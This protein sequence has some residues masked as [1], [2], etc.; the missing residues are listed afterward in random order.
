M[1]NESEPPDEGAEGRSASAREQDAALAKRRSSF[2]AVNDLFRGRDVAAELLADVWVYA[3]HAAKPDEALADPLENASYAQAQDAHDRHKVLDQYKDQ[4]EQGAEIRAELENAYSAQSRKA[5]AAPSPETPGPI[6]AVL[7][8]WSSWN[9]A[10]LADLSQAAAAR[11]AALK[12]ALTP[13][14]ETTLRDLETGKGSTLATAKIFRS[15]PQLLDVFPDTPLVRKVR[16]LIQMLNAPQEWDGYLD[17]LWTLGQTLL[18]IVTGDPWVVDQGSNDSGRLRENWGQ[19]K[20]AI[21]I[22]TL[23]LPREHV[24][25]MADELRRRCL[26][27]RMTA[28]DG[29]SRRIPKIE[30]RHLKIVL[31]NGNNPFVQRI[32]QSTLEPATIV[33]A[34]DDVV[35]ERVEVLREFPPEER[36]ED[37]GVTAPPTE[38][39]VMLTPQ[40]GPSS[41]TQPEVETIDLPQG[42]LSNSIMPPRLEIV[43]C[44]PTT[45]SNSPGPSDVQAEWRSAAAPAAVKKA[46]DASTAALAPITLPMLEAAAEEPPG[47]EPMRERWLVY[48]EAVGTIQHRLNASVGRSQAIFVKA[49]TSNE[50]RCRVSPYLSSFD[51]GLKIDRIDGIVGG[52]LRGITTATHRNSLVPGGSVKSWAQIDPRDVEVDKSDLSDWLNQQAPIASPA[53]QAPIPEPDDH[54]IVHSGAPGRPTSKQLVVNEHA[55]RITDGKAVQGLTCQAEALGR[56]LQ[57]KH[58]SAPRMKVK[59]IEN[60]IR[61]AHRKAS[62]TGPTTKPRNKPQN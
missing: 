32:R 59:T 3:D 38:A 57:E 60:A 10:D 40:R 7:E 30:W 47:G 25:D 51:A 46:D 14:R 42:R 35:F 20:A 21:L 12:S 61:E 49:V 56:W 44:S 31:D 24:R 22:D 53:P 55:R 58:P 29:Q 37:Q 9:A 6:A 26:S 27:G 28:I 15:V 1:T 5:Q 43:G 11:H 13:E 50:L 2:E 16:E 18:W 17:E 48:R 36:S 39:D 41:A 4:L 23:N 45:W 33:P 8:L 52:C 62:L 34:C 19:I 54:E